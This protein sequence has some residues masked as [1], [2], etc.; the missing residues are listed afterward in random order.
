M[1][2]AQLELNASRKSRRPLLVLLPDGSF[3]SLEHDARVR[4]VHRALVSGDAVAIPRFALKHE[5]GWVE[6]DRAKSPAPEVRGEFCEY[7]VLINGKEVEKGHI[8]QRL[9]VEQRRGQPTVELLSRVAVPT[10]LAGE[11]GRKTPFTIP[12]E[13]STSMS[14]IHRR[15]FREAAR[16]VASAGISAWTRAQLK[17]K[18]LHSVVALMHAARDG[19]AEK[20]ASLLQR[21]AGGD[22]NALTADGT[23]GTCCSPALVQCCDVLCALAI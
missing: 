1:P 14:D 4:L 21:G 3:D 16:K 10:P 5:A 22:V 15:R 23:S 2:H 12:A 20:L 11:P 9:Q 8:L 6:T 18:H 13:A 17:T 19:D 7:V